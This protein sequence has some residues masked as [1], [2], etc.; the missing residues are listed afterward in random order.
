MGEVAM[1]KILITLIVSSFVHFFFPF[2]IMSSIG[3]SENNK[4]LLQKKEDVIS[5]F[6]NRIK[7]LSREN[8]V[9][10]PQSQKSWF[11]NPFKGV[12]FWSFFPKRFARNY[13]KQTE[14]RD[15]RRVLLARQQEEAVLQKQKMRDAEVKASIE[16]DL[17][18]TDYEQRLL[19]AIQE[20][21]KTSFKNL[22]IKRPCSS[23]NPHLLTEDFTDES[24]RAAILKEQEKNLRLEDTLQRQ[25]YQEHPE[26]RLEY[27]ENAKKK[28]VMNAEQE[29]VE[30][31][32]K[33]LERQAAARKQ[34]QEYY[35]KEDY[36]NRGLWARIKNMDF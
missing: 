30:A 26:L 27:E 8:Q 34:A 32:R 24:N 28:A 13:L 25:F 1:K 4:Q 5:S 12:N 6:E 20:L 19:K 3:L 14:I 10:K 23:L 29:K 36:E 11:S 15:A 31:E 21:Q 7:L 18:V 17:L 16:A 22:E 9:K 2:H 33:E 35:G